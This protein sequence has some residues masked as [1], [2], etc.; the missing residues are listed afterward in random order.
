MFRMI[1]VDDEAE[2]ARMI[3]D[4]IDWSSLGIE[5][6]DVCNDGTAGLQAIMLHRPDIVITD[7][8]MPQMRG[9]ELIKKATDAG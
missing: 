3:R 9:I 7:V 1:I 2:M 6:V 8:C 5:V 4:L